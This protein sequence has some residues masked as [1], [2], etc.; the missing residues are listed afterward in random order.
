MQH[1]K[2]L[3]GMQSGRTDRHPAVIERKIRSPR[4]PLPGSSCRKTEPVEPALIPQPFLVF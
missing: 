2:F 3:D 4:I 1:K